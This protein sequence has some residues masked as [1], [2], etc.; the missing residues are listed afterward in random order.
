[1]PRELRDNNRVTLLV[2]NWSFPFSTLLR[3]PT[4]AEYPVTSCFFLKF[5][6]VV[7]WVHE[8]LRYH[9]AT[10]IDL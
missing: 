3:L 1:M 9:V 7:F 6:K 10:D 8:P 5:L 2:T 4:T